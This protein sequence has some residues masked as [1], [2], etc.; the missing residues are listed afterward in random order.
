M[1]RE[2]VSKYG[3]TERE[4]NTF[5]SLLGKL[6]FKK[7]SVSDVKYKLR[8]DTLPNEDEWW[9]EESLILLSIIDNPLLNPQ[10]K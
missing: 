10:K 3:L 2:L 6:K 1:E 8:Y 4:A 7:K 9:A 5:V